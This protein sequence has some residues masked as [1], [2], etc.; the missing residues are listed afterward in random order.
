M[1]IEIRA[2]EFSSAAE[3]IQYA[4]ASGGEAILLNCCRLVLRQAE[5]KR[6][7]RLVVP[8]ADAERLEAAGVSFAYLRDHEMPDGSHRIMTIPVND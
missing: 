7:R 8:Q 3:A 4:D 6:L 1:T 2:T 5:A